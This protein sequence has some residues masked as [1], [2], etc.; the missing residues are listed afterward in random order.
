M[1]STPTTTAYFDTADRTLAIVTGT[2][3]TVKTVPVP[4]TVA[5]AHRNRQATWARGVLRRSG[6]TPSQEVQAYPYGVAIPT[7]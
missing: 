7:V 1:T 6:F 3:K 5:T 2:G 4:E